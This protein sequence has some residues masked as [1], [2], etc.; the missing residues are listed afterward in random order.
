MRTAL[1]LPLAV[2]AVAISACAPSGEGEAVQPAAD[3]LI[4]FELA[5]A[6]AA[7]STA[8]DQIIGLDTAQLAALLE[9]GNVRLIDV[10][11]ADEVAQ[12]M[13]AGTEHIAMDAFDPA[14]LDPAD[15]RAI[16]LYCR[17][18]RRSQIVGE[19]LAEYRGEPTMHLSGGILAWEADGYPIR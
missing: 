13:I 14:D 10:R 11:T 8:P 6:K 9:R 18:G 12:G 3:A 1:S 5:S 15:E 19:K 17:S 16:V 2:L 4:G 7:T